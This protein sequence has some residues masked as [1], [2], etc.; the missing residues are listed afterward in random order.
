MESHYCVLMLEASFSETGG[1]KLLVRKAQGIYREVR[2]LNSAES[3]FIHLH[4]FTISVLT[5]TYYV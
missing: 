2:I 4:P 1:T 5:F 3:T